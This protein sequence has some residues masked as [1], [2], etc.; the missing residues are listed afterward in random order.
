MT[1]GK[2]TIDDLIFNDQE[3]IN[4]FVAEAKE[5]LDSIEEDFLN[6]EK[7]GD[8]PD[9]NLVD[10][11]FRA[12]HSVKGAAGFLGLDNMI[13][14]AHA[15][16]TI[17]SRMR[18][19]EINPEAEY[20]DA[21]LA[22]VDLI[23]IMLDDIK[24]SVKVDISSIHKRLSTLLE[25]GP[26]RTEFQTRRRSQESSSVTDLQN[27]ITR[28]PILD[29]TGVDFGHS[30]RIDVDVLDK[31][32][33][34]AGELVLV[35]NQYMLTVDN[36][37]PVFRS[38]SQQLDAV[39]S[40]LQETIIGT[41]MQPIGKI[42]G[43]I[44]R[45]VRELEKTLGKKIQTNISGSESELDRT[46]LESLADPMT[47]II[48]NS[49]GHG[50]ESPKERV[51]AGKTE[52]GHL[53]IMAYHEGG[54]FNIK[55]SDD[56]KGI[57]PALVRRKVLEKALISEA[58]LEQMSD[59]DVLHLIMLPGFSTADKISDVLG[60]GVGMDVVKTGIEK[61]GGSLDLESD[62]G[63][64][65]TIHLR[66]PL[67][68]AIIP[69]LIISSGGYRYAIPQTSLEE[70]V[71]LYDEDVK[72]KIECADDQEV[73]R[74]RNSLLPM[75]RLSEVL[76]R[77]R[78]F[79]RE[80]RAEI[81][82]KYRKI[83]D[84]AWKNFKK[85]DKRG[86]DVKFSQSLIFT[87]LRAGV[88]RF[89][90][91]IDDILGTEE[92]V[93]KPMHWAVKSLGI[94][95]GATIMGDG[96]SALI[97]DVEGIAR[98]AGITLE[99]VFEKAE[100]LLDKTS[101]EEDRQTVLLFKSGKEEQF[102]LSL[103]LIR[104]LEP[105]SMSDIEL[106]GDKE[107][108]TVDGVSTRIIRL[109]HILSV[110][111]VVEHN[112]MF[113]ILPRHVRQPVGI[114][115]SGLIDIEETK[116][117][118]NVDSYIEDGLLGTAIV[119]GSMT[120]FLDMY[121]L[122]EIIYQDRHQSQSVRQKTP[123]RAPTRATRQVLMLEHD[124][125]FRDLVTKYLETEGY[126]VTAVDKGQAGI[127][128]LSEM[129]FDIVVSD[130]DIPGMDGWEFMKRVRQGTHQQD[131]PAVALTALNTKEDRKKAAACGFDRYEIK[132]DRKSLLTTLAEL[133]AM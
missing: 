69:S 41:R 68:L 17:L 16:E 118:L 11:V 1:N 108:I 130:L 99:G 27:E 90:L 26:S 66:L 31:L 89:G 79:N 72:T 13:K 39:T 100:G 115:T 119:R 53:T 106:L 110:S 132:L 96:V 88:N 122:V 54:Q 64:G 93:V 102:A 42:F 126:H 46:I 121:R 14:L 83:Q 105:I 127:D 63:K 71:R 133:L 97:L 38:V 111:K 55:V 116:T 22:G 74:L 114:L 91:I 10:K 95:S 43:K 87:V 2:E 62:P 65:T 6:L 76:A 84:K 80:A 70:L 37:D 5:H 48:R 75:V 20:I 32:M 128:R 45:M 51:A 103:H 86:S 73:Y 57:D 94:Y 23:T 18:S 120:L 123:S 67:T 82:E 21:L 52:V 44:P 112:E 92:I 12:I 125:F 25:K 28:T 98:H 33:V 9:Q 30:V 29:M 34:L 60:R 47:H 85:A 78:P 40:E 117:E 3:T 19:R 129:E 107:Y 59:K 35:R 113:L 50:I 58:E 131:I 61:L 7:Q 124:P 36:S 109:D 81:T 49:C 15:M 104:R 8:N 4:S 101:T 56:G 77:P 24:E